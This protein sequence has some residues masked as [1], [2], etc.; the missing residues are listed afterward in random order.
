MLGFSILVKTVRPLTPPPLLPCGT[1]PGLARW[2]EELALA[3]SQEHAC[4]PLYSQNRQG[5]ELQV[6]TLKD[7]QTLLREGGF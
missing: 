3:A 1:S 6:C 5:W 4:C 7:L 2:E